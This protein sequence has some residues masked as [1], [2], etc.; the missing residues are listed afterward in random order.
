MRNKLNSI[1][2]KLSFSGYVNNTM[3]KSKGMKKDNR[4]NFGMLIVFGL[5]FM[6]RRK[7]TSEV[8][9]INSVTFL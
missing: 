7:Q 8:F 6:H 2:T 1:Y 5:S 3:R 4:K 9:F